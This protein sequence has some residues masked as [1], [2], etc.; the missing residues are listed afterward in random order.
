VLALSAPQP[1]LSTDRG[2]V[3]VMVAAW[4]PLLALFASFAIDFGH[5]FD[6]SRNLQNRADAAA[7]AAGTQYGGVCFG[8]PSRAELDNIG[9]TAQQYSGPLAGADLPYA[10]AQM[11]GRTTYNVPNLKAGAAS[12]LHVLLNSNQSWDKGGTDFSMGTFCDASENGSSIG[13]AVDVKITQAQLPLFLPLVG[14]QPNINANARVQLQEAESESN[15]SPIAVA[16]PAQ[17]PCVVGRILDQNTGTVIS[18]VTMSKLSGSNPPTFTGT[19]SAPI[20]PT[21]GA[22]PDQL[23]VQAFLPDDC[24]N[25]TGS[26]TLY[27]DTSQGGGI[28]F[29]NTYKPL[30]ATPPATGAN[31]GSVFLTVAGCDDAGESATQASTAGAAYFYWYVKGN[32]RVT[33]NAYVDFPGMSKAGNG[34][35]I[36]MDG[37]KAQTA[38]GGAVDG[39]GHQLWTSTFTIPPQSGR[40]TFVVSYFDGTQACK[41]ANKPCAFN[42]GNPLQETMSARD[43]GLDP[44]DD[45]GSVGLLQVGS[46]AGNPPVVQA[47][48]G[49]DSLAQGTATTLMLSFQLRGLSYAQPGDP[50]IVLRN[51]VQNSKKTGFIDCGQGNGG[52]SLRPAL[53][54]GCPHSLMIY[55][56]PSCP[57][58]TTGAGPWSCVGTVSGNKTGPMRQGMD[59]RIGTSCDNWLAYPGTSI[60]AGDPRVMTLVITSSG[61]LAGSSGSGVVRVLG[62]A[63][64]YVTGYDGISNPSNKCPAPT[65]NNEAN[66]YGGNGNG[67]SEFDIWGHFIEFVSNTGTGNGKT[68]DPVDVFGDCVAALTR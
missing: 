15:T 53:G 2:A 1:R 48:G 67:G 43:D 55:N 18:T 25:P 58:A 10:A 14:F 54:S 6:Y 51:S 8:T 60:P 17:T 50:P 24:S 52:G 37:N 66:P 9:E 41:N 38:S 64:F 5:F 68:C 13:P 62:F 26:G 34:V 45:S 42:G 44:P 21:S 4:L 3:M 40:H 59:D 39:T 35:V 11:T 27:D 33:V 19:T 36:T 29:I 56:G 23:T 30:P 31:V 46:V 65:D 61:D 16:D 49:L 32:C 20:S 7:L 12:K 57:P 28:A 22:Q 47:T 63:S